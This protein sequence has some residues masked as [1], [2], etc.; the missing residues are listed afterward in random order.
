MNELKKLLDGFKDNVGIGKKEHGIV[1]G[2]ES[3]DAILLGNAEQNLQQLKTN[4][5]SAFIGCCIADG[6]ESTKGI[7]DA[8]LEAAKAVAMY[9][10]D[11][12]QSIADLKIRD[13][14]ESKNVLKTDVLEPGSVSHQEIIAAAESYDSQKIDFSSSVYH[15]MAFNAVA[16]KQDPV[17]ELFYPIH[18]LDPKKAGFKIEA[19]LSYV[20]DAVERNISGAVT[21]FNRQP[22]LKNLQ[23]TD[24][25]T[26]EANRLYPIVR[27]QSKENLVIVDGVDGL[28]EEVQVGS[29]ATETTG[30]IATGKA[31]D[32]LGISQPTDLLTKGV[33]DQ[34]DVL[35]KYLVVEKILIKL[36]GKNAEGA[37]I[38]EYFTR[39][40]AGL[41]ATF[42]GGN[43]ASNG[44]DDRSLN[45]NYSTKSIAFIGGNIR[46]A[47]DIKTTDADLLSLT[48]GYTAK[49]NIKL[50]GDANVETG[51]YEVNPG[52]INLIEVL[53]VAGNP[54][55]ELSDNYIKAK[56][57]ISNMTVVGTMPKAYANN[58]NGR[59]RS[60]KLTT[61]SK[62]YGYTVQT[63]F[64]IREETSVH[65]DK[66]SDTGLTG[67][68]LFTQQSMN[69]HGL[70][71]LF[72]TAS[73]L[74]NTAIDASE[75]GLTD[76]I[77]KKS[78]ISETLDIS[79]IVD[80]VD[81]RGR[82]EDIKTALEL[83]IREIA[84]TLSKESGYKEIFNLTHGNVKPT[85]A[86][87]VDGDLGLFLDDFSDASFNYVVKASSDILM[88]DKIVIGFTVM[89]GRN[90]KPN[91][92]SFGT[93]A[94]SPEIVIAGTRTGQTYV[95]ETMIA[96]RYRHQGFQQ[97]MGVIDVTGLDKVVG[98]IA[99]IM[100]TV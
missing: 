94:W 89:E 96:P 53:D 39:E 90:K 55:S 98:K 12:I 83:Q 80:S 70:L 4:I 50:N 49:L 86:I 58:D 84:S 2:M 17:V 29:G 44:D 52:T 69:K 28:T 99:T 33:M 82:R 100:H 59:F 92:F 75:M 79:A 1:A 93:T 74:S 16:I 88:R 11:P 54:V 66:A 20:M 72:K 73:Y 26:L 9:A 56:E 95:S 91:I 30:Y 65:G 5:D 32:L 68:V 48:D 63:R 25:F 40:L 76:D 67:Q 35:N 46:Q 77:F 36:N 14:I 61:I 64:V 71:E 85:V 43:Q 37:D 24:L 42:F 7:S 3:K 27:E 6:S 15:S 8:K 18:I 34:T 21:K 97:I 22:I 81:H 60:R 10:I 38:E 47:S 57:A 62:S 45:L 19:E 23:N 51:S 13:G 31:V 78:F 41:P 87:G